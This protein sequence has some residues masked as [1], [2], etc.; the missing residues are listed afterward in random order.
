LLREK[1]TTDKTGGDAKKV[2]SAAGEEKIACFR[3]GPEKMLIRKRNNTLPGVGETRAVKKGSKSAV[4]ET[5]GVN[6]AGTFAKNQKKKKKKKNP[7]PKKKT[8]NPKKQ[9]PTQKKT[10]TKQKN[11]TQREKCH[12]TLRRGCG[13]KENKNKGE[14]LDKSVQERKGFQRPKCLMFMGGNKKREKGLEIRG[15]RKGS[16]QQRGKGAVYNEKKPV[17]VWKKGDFERRVGGKK[18][19]LELR[20]QRKIASFGEKGT[21]KR[22]RMHN[23]LR[24][25]GI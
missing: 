24:I 9:P 18:P 12:V 15:V 7:K 10:T 14:G 21:K 17:T 23:G 8:T 4:A 16:S 13:K 1:S 20:R 3:P 22:K 2:G 19:E 6:A 5:N 11:P 25:G